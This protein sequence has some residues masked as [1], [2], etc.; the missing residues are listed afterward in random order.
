M[1]APLSVRLYG[2]LLGLLPRS[3]R[4]SDGSAMLETFEDLAADQDSRSG[5]FALFLRCFIGLLG[6]AMTEHTERLLPHALRRETWWAWSKDLVYATRTLRRSPGFALTAILLLGLGI[7]A[8]T[9]IFTLVDHILLRP[10]PYPTPSRLVVLEDG[11]HTGPLFRG[12]EELPSVERWAGSWS[13]TTNL[14]GEGD[15]KQLYVANV[16]EDFFSLFGARAARGRLLNRED[17]ETADR[18]ALSHGLWTRLFGADPQV[19]GETLRLDG[20]A[21]TIV[22]VVD[23]RFSTPEA[24][25]GPKIDLYRPLD[26]SREELAR[27]DTYVLEVAGRLSAGAVPE[28]LEREVEQL[29]TRLDK[30]APEQYRDREENL[31]LP[32][33]SRLED[34]TVRGVRT[35]LHLLLGAVGLLLAIACSNVGHLFLARGLTRGPEI[36]VRRSLGASTASLVRQLLLEGLIVAIVGGALGVILASFTVKS[37]LSAVPDAVPRES[38]VVL[39]LRVL[40]FAALLSGATVLA[41]GLI[42]ALRTTGQADRSLSQRASTESQGIGALRGGLIVGEI[43]MAMML[44]A[45]S[46]VLFTSFLEVTRQDSGL[47]AAHVLTVPLNTTE[48]ETPEAYVTEMEEIRRELSLIPGASDISYALAMPFS[49][50]GGSR[51]CWRRRLGQVPNEEDG[52]L[53][54]SHPVST[55]YFESL[56]IPLVAGALW[57]ASE[58]QA[59][60]MPIVLTEETAV[61]QFGSASQA[62]GKSLFGRDEEMI[63]KAVVGDNRHFG[64]DQE[65]GQALYMPIEAVPFGNDMAEFAVRFDGPAPDGTAMSVRQAIWRAAPAQPVPEVRNLGHHIDASTA[66]RRFDSLLSG[67][68]A[69]V[70]L[71]LTAGGLYGTLLYTVGR[72]RREMGIRLALGAGRFR[73]ERDVLASALRLG[74]LGMSLG[75]VGAWAISRF[76][77]SRLWGIE[78]TDPRAFGAAAIALLLTVLISGWLPA[79]RAARIDPVEALRAE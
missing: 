76:L 65:H 28:D 47:Q 74:V 36:A 38:A 5:R 6:V 73:V 56:G 33:I 40:A 32:P 27:H 58:A 37:L 79:R 46:S 21:V 3:I 30:E 2:R 57:T 64:L 78:A 35:S 1:R 77:Q 31:W 54:S 20:E 44:L 53:A 62:L 12:L 45:A 43:A 72:R 19:V 14:T 23:R 11:S 70:A 66:M 67:S 7:G 61:E 13:G 75:L 8:V 51:C 63:V 69:T 16:T 15:P 17:F 29:L 48:F 4:E 52:F 26:W 18:V 9:S 42:P 68:F 41:F 24:L 50:T 10:L 60:P 22:G 49:F 55:G 59:V 25:T 34:V 71:L 39:D